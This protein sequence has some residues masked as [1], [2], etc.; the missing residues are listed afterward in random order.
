MTPILSSIR[1]LRG[2]R[3]LA[4]VQECFGNTQQFSD[5]E[6][7][8][9]EQ[10]RRL[11][12]IW[13]ET[14]ELVPRYQSLLRTRAVPRIFQSLEEFRQTVPMTSR[15]EVRSS[16]KEFLNPKLSQDQFRC[17]GGSTAEPIRFP[18]N[19]QEVRYTGAAAWLV[20]TWIGIKPE[21]PLFL[22]WGHSHLFGTGWKGWLNQKK[23]TYSDLVLGYCRYS[24][25]D[26]SDSALQ[27]AADCLLKFRP[28]WCLGYSVA[29]DRFA[30]AN[31]ERRNELRSLGLKAIIATA[32]AFPRD[33]SR[34]RIASLFGCPV[35]MEYGAVET[36][37]LAQEC[38]AGDYRAVWQ[39][40][41][42]EV[43]ESDDNSGDKELIVTSLFPRCLSLMRYRIGD[44]IRGA[45]GGTSVV[46]FSAV[47]GRCND[48]LQLS[49]GKQIHSE[50]LAHIL[51][52]LPGVSSYQAIQNDTCSITLNLI[53]QGEL[54]RSLQETIQQRLSKLDQSLAK[55][56]VAKVD[57]L[58]QSIAGKTPT[59]VRR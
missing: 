30:E 59:I 53:L 7:I 26:M 50:A 25:Y 12:A 42:L 20:R 22:L 58:Q 11:N 40:H 3:V 4:S 15:D 46:S 36:G 44:R 16:L 41:L 47:S 55:T 18:I 27:R 19:S 45:S 48:F 10:L 31:H 38:A 29:W 24:A 1:W 56:S 35:L 33:D 8:H 9:S 14:C 54:S 39:N 23:R 13:T 17:T 21:D 49:S 51:R 2:R 28:R 52:D 43:L 34:D 32:E 37:I 5:D 6:A 57:Q